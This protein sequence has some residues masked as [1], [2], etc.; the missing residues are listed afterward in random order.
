M[1]DIAD[2]MGEDEITE[3]SSKF[4]SFLFLVLRQ[5]IM[6][7]IRVNKIL[8]NVLLQIF[9]NITC[10]NRKTVCG[11]EYYCYKLQMRQNEFNIMFYEAFP[12][13]AHGHVCKGRVYET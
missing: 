9:L 6:I 2:D 10:H 3:E 13:V 1:E 4:F 11:R 5:T 8:V 12:A 7:I